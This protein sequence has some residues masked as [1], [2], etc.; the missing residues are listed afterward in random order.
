MTELPNLGGH[1]DG[2]HVTEGGGTK[3]VVINAL[4][5]L[6]DNAQNKPTVLDVTAGGTFNLDTPSANLDQF[7]ESSFIQITGTPAGA[8]AVVMPDGNKR[9]AFENICGQTATF[10][11]VTGAASPVVMS[12][13]TTKTIQ[14]RGIEITITA[15]D[16][17]QT[18]ALLKDGSTPM[19]GDQDWADQELQRPVLKDYAESLSSPAAAATVDLDLTTGNVFDVTLDQD[20]TFTFSNPPASG[21]AGS[22][23]LIIRQD[24]TGGHSVTMPAS[25]DWEG[26]SGPTFSTAA[27]LVDI[28]SFLTVDGGTTWFGF[29]GGLNFA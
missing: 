12:T 2:T 4:T 20:T 13:G 9:I 17:Q 6:V 7:L 16:A 11:T 8:V 29:L 28:A 27:G 18:G 25:V 15:D 19:T 24:G 21:K 3:E 10:D 23:T 22:F 1:T 26:G 5:N 14:V